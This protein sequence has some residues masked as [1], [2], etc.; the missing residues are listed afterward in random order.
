MGRLLARF[1]RSRRFVVLV[2]D[3]KGAPRGFRSAGCEAAR[4]ADV[5]VIAAALSRSAEALDRVLGERPRGLVFDVASV[6][7]PLLRSIERGRGAGVSIAS[8]HPMFGPDARS[9][10]GRDLVVCDCGD[11]AAARRAA[12]L[13]EGAGLRIVRMPVAAHDAAVAR[14]LGLAHLVGLA[15]AAALAGDPPPRDAPA[16]TSYRLLRALADTVLAQPAD[17]TYAIQASNPASPAVALR[18]AS[19]VAAL[20]DLLEGADGGAS[21]ARALDRWRAAAPPKRR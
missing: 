10:R 6:K 13:F 8:V 16:S 5:V 19:S 18:F 17:L 12:R 1:F 14:T 2:C 3:P 9:F 21:L 15:A 20:A 4:E 11:A 7:A